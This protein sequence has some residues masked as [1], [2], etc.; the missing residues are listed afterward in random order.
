MPTDKL[1]PAIQEVL[2]L[3]LDRETSGKYDSS[4]FDLGAEF[5][6]MLMLR[7]RGFMCVEGRRWSLTEAGRAALAQTGHTGDVK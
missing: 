2:R 7:R 5:N 6:F 4:P 1:T 3:A